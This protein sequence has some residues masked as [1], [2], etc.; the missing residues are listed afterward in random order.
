[1][2]DLCVNHGHCGGRKHINDFLPETG[3]LAAKDF[4]SMV[5][6]AEEMDLRYSP[7]EEER[8][9]QLISGLFEQHLGARTVDVSNIKGYPKP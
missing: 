9:I 1:M 2:H 8:Q 4:A 5:L 3:P 6:E 7:R